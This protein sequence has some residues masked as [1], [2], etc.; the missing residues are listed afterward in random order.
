LVSKSN[1]IGATITASIK[2]TESGEHTEITFSKAESVEYKTVLNQ[3][4]VAGHSMQVVYK[5]TYR[6]EEPQLAKNKRT[7]PVKRAGSHYLR[8]ENKVGIR[9]ARKYTYQ[10]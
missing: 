10:R 1:Q 2:D 8:A 5:R 3:G 7:K 9:R 4:S 6:R